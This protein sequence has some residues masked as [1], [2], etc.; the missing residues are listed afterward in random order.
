M[1]RILSIFLFVAGA[2]YAATPI[3]DAKLTGQTEISGTLTVPAGTTI[4]GLA[5]VEQGAKA[6]TAVQAWYNLLGVTTGATGRPQAIRFT[7][8]ASSYYIT[9][10][11]PSSIPAGGYSVSLPAAGGMIAL[12]PTYCV[13]T[14]PLGRYYDFEQSVWKLASDFEAKATESNFGEHTPFTDLYAYYHSPDPARASVSGQTG[15]KPV[16]VY[17]T[18]S[19]NPDKRRWLRQP[20]DQSIY[21][22]RKSPDSI[23]SAAI[24]VFAVDA[25]IRPDNPNL[26]WS[27]QRISGGSYE[28]IW[29]PIMPTWSLVKPTP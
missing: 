16:A 29:T 20:A 10:H 14:I 18:D 15:P 27:Y 8:G 26:V 25:K 6:D 4:N 21:A 17:Y 13:L 7:P 2:A 19:K 22:A 11:A 3:K 5:T 24:V 23:I 1:T 12:Q 28:N 9:L